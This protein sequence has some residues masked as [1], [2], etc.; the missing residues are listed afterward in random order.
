MKGGGRPGG[1]SPALRE[2]AQLFVGN[3]E[4]AGENYTVNNQ[5]SCK[6]HKNFLRELCGFTCPVKPLL[7]FHRGVST[8]APA[9]PDQGSEDRDQGLVQSRVRGIIQIAIDIEIG[10][11]KK[12]EA[13]R[14]VQDDYC[15][16]IMGKMI[17][18]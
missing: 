1:V 3:R 15:K 4:C 8:F 12:Q 5:I 6:N 11:D 10:I 17:R 14:L 9:C 18:G 16:T 7:L 13:G 2:M